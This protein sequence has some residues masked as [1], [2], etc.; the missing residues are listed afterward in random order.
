[1]R[2][3]FTGA[4]S[5]AGRC[6][7]ERLLQTPEDIGV[8]CLRHQRDMA[9]ADARVR[10]IDLNLAEPF[11]E[12]SLPDAIDL[13]IHFAG[14]T[15]ARDPDRYWQTNLRGTAQLS[16]ASRA[17]GCRRF[18]YISTRC[19]TSGS[20]AYGESKLAAEN[21]LKKADW[22]SLLIIRPSEI[23]GA[24]GKEGVDKLIALARRW[25]LTP[26][27]FGTSKI[28]FAPLH[29]E[30][31]TTIV[32]DE[33]MK[34]ANGLRIIELCGPEDLGA[35]ALAMRIAR[36]YQALPI[37]LWWPLFALLLKTAAGFNLGLAVPDQLVRLTCAKSGSAKSANRTGRFRF[38]LD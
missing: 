17:R 35:T 38:L 18:V 29:I 3:L 26:W 33:I 32:A 22:D 20:G 16:E 8:W 4:S 23:Y 30:D 7:L 25:H 28:E 5:I 10:V 9:S 34:P 31:F 37:P 24:G 15:H 13:V 14:V 21:E 6:V 27:L 19:A 36:R 11:A 2:I 1:M 12:E